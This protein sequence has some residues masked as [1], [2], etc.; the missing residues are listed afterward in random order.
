MNAIAHNPYRVL[1]MFANDPLRTE[2]ANIA[3]IR[4]FNKVGKECPFES[5]FIDIFGSIDRSEEAIER[6]ITLLSSDDDRDYY[7][8]L[9]IHRV[10]PLDSGAKAPVDIIR[11]GLGGESKACIVNVIVGAFYADNIELASEYIIRLFECDD[12]PSETTKERF[13]VELENGYKDEYEWPPFIWW[14]RLRDFCNCEEG[15]SKTLEFISKVY[16]KESINYLRQLSETES[17]GKEC[18]GYISIAS[19]HNIAKPVIEVIKET[20]NLQTKQPNAEAQI[21]LS[22]Y[23]KVI[24]AA[25]KNYY[26]D[27]RFWEAKPVE[28]L[29]E[30]LREVYRLSYSSKVKEECTS[31]GKE[32]K[33]E[34]QFLA[35]SQVSSF[36][37]IIRKEIEAFCSKPN[38]TRWSLQ[39]LRNCVSPLIEIKTILGAD[40]PYYRRIST[41]IADNA[42]YASEAEIDSAE[43]KLNNPRNDKVIALANLINALG[44]ATQLCVDIS[45][46]DIED[47]FRTAKVVKFKDKI[48]NCTERNKVKVGATKPSIS[49]ESH[50]DI[51]QSCNDY[52]SLVDFTLSYPESPHF[53]EAIQRIWKIEDDEYPKD[54]S[55]TAKALLAYKEKFPN[56]HN[57]QKIL[58]SLDG[59]L[60]GR[61]TLGTVYDYRTILRLWPDHPKKSVVLGRLDL[62]SFKMCHNIEG[63][64]EYLKEFPNGLYREEAIKNIQEIKDKEEL[65]AFNRCQTIKDFCRF[66]S[67]YPSGTLHLKAKIKIE[68][69]YYSQALQTGQYDTYFHQYP[70]GRYV[71]ALNQL[72]DDK[73]FEV[74]KTKEDY[75]NYVKLYPQGSHVQ[76]AKK[77]LKEERR[78]IIIVA[79]S[80]AGIL[81]LFGFVAITIQRA[82][83]YEPPVSTVKAVDTSN[84]SNQSEENVSTYDNESN[85]R[86]VADDNSTYSV[87]SDNETSYSS[88]QESNETTYNSY[89]AYRN[90]SLE[91]GAKPYASYFGKAQTGKN[92]IDFKTSGSSDYIAIVKRHS[93]NR[94][95]N[96]IYIKGGDNARLYVPSGTYD[97]YFYSGSGWNPNMVVGQFTGGFVEGG[98][99]QKDGPI[100]L[101]SETITMDDGRTQLRTA[102]MEYTLYPV[103]NG[104]LVLQNADIDNVLN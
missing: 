20:S 41:Q 30:L 10:Q 103:T 82:R 58:D 21:V 32:V 31:F 100:Q 38:E 48:D 11:S 91:T 39:L 95:I 101:V 96:H 71:K 69:L 64:T 27:T 7:S 66:V 90:N 97:V 24:L 16:N 94:Y 29:L 8:S 14:S 28:K 76:E 104:N 83:E 13:L 68:N 23:A 22:K 98:I 72:I 19:A 75:K 63:W 33:K 55:L 42:L 74:C 62:A 47:D 46:L 3:R 40:D 44:Q 60:L 45:V 77:Y 61:G 15:H 35:P 59:M 50:D 52:N 70:N 53:K 25:C 26:K 43:R 80:I 93:N 57:D 67:L 9:W 49:L 102:Y 54:Y 81:F 65:E 36:S 5:D 56:S 12:A 37:T 86:T 51:Y 92:Y 85:N 4:A 34:V 2:T 88:D 78:K 18:K 99:M 79:A 84:P 87:E 6:A 73:R 1:G 89:D 17:L